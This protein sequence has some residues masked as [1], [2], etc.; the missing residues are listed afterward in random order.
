MTVLT[1]MES[2]RSVFPEKIV[3]DLFVQ[4]EVEVFVA[5]FEWIQL[6]FVISSSLFYVVYVCQFL[7]NCFNDLVN[8]VV[9][10]E[11]RHFQ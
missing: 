9:L 1:Q 3:L 2:E 5:C 4:Q 11:I 7:E 8:V 6:V 10:I